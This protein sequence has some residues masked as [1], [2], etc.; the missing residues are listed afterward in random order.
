[1]DLQTYL[2][3]NRISRSNFAKILEIH[4]VYFQHLLSGRHPIT[5]S[6]A[7]KIIRATGGEVSYYSL[8]GNKQSPKDKISLARRNK[9]I[10]KAIQ[11][12]AFKDL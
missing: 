9:K 7:E 10:P 3:K 11:L 4:R 5:H 6:M 1:M 12:D 2:A 8:T